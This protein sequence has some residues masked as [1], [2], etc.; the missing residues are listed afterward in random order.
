MDS[1]DA[2]SPSRS[3]YRERRLNNS[4]KMRENELASMMSF[5]PVRVSTQCA[6]AVFVQPPPLHPRTS[7][8]TDLHRAAS[9]L[10]RRS[11]DRQVRRDSGPRRG[12]DTIVRDRRTRGWSL[13]GEA[14]L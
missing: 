10:R 1:S 5:R 11:P 12:W 4:R 9:V 2:L 8:L 13:G 14:G 7:A 3:R 6:A